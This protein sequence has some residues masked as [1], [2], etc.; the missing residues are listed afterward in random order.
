[1]DKS[2]L[3]GAALWALRVATWKSEGIAIREGVDEDEMGFVTA[4][5]R[6]ALSLFTLQTQA[7]VMQVI[8]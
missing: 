2:D 3:K 7:L 8:E 1:M 6:K 5:A 4:V